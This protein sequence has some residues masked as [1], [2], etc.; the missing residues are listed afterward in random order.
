MTGKPTVYF[1]KSEIYKRMIFRYD[2]TSAYME[3]AGSS[4]EQWS[5]DGWY[6][7]SL[8]PF[9]QTTIAGV[10]IV[11]AGVVMS[12]FFLKW[13]L[14]K[15]PQDHKVAIHGAP[16]GGIIASIANA[17]QIQIT[18]ALYER[19]ALWLND[20]ENHRT[21]TG[22][23]DAL[24]AKT[25]LFQVSLCSTSFLWS[26]PRIGLRDVFVPCNRMTVRQ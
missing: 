12:I 26:T 15:S 23:E 2:C 21:E 9:S 3:E 17:I 10:I 4:S 11:V 6:S 13:F 25:F 8:C 22:F 5:T 7:L 16:L 18:N 14:L 20:L 1:P 24:I 19:L